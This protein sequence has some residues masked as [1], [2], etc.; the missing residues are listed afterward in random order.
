MTPRDIAV[1]HDGTIYI[2]EQF[3]RDI[4]KITPD[5]YITWVFGNNYDGFSDFSMAP[6]EAYPASHV[7]F[8]HNIISID[9]RGDGTLL[10][11]GDTGDT[12][13]EVSPSGIARVV[14]GF[15]SLRDINTIGNPVM[16]V[17]NAYF[18]YPKDIRF[19]PGGTPYAL[20]GRRL[21]RFDSDGNFRAV[22]GHG[23][24]TGPSGNGGPPLRGRLVD[25]RQLDFGPNG[26][27]YIA[28]ANGHHV[29]R[30]GPPLP[31]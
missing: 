26:D 29:R 2:L 27:L 14:A 8:D 17:Q 31:G 22:V 25:S 16:P 28:E 3:Q 11:I 13:V 6:G 20:F 15:D 23:E 24:L 10:V 12:V 1:A 30:V 7:Y 9:V 5:G 21:Y 19:G 18:T 4:R